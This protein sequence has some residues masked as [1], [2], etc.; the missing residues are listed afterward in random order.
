MECSKCKEKHVACARNQNVQ[1]LFFESTS[2]TIPCVM[3]SVATLPVVVGRD[4]LSRYCSLSVSVLLR[5]A[6]KVKVKFNIEQAMKFQKGSRGV[7]CTARVFSFQSQV[8]C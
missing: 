1:P 6:Y 2:C 5:A 3:I 4:F 8:P 7:V